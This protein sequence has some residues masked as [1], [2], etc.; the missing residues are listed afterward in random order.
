MVT[1][2]LP[3]VRVP[4]LFKLLPTATVPKLR[5]E[6]E[7]PNCD[8]LIPVPVNG[9]LAGSAAPTTVI[10]SEPFTATAAL[11]AN[12][13]VMVVDCPGVRTMG[14]EAVVIPKPV[15]VVAT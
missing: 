7:T 6:G 15:P 4:V 11:G 3:A 12:V 1:S 10:D 5:V 9:T 14:K 13:M 8:T 2:E